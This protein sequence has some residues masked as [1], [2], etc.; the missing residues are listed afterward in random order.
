[1]KIGYARVSTEGQS[2]D[3]QL[4]ALRAEK[5]DRIFREKVSGGS[6]RNRPELAKAIDALGK[7]DVLVVAEWDRA[8]RSLNDGLMLIARVNDRGAR[9]KVLDRPFLDLTSAFGRG[10]MALLSGLAEDERERINRR[11]AEG[12]KAA[13]RRGTRMG[14]P[15]ALN[16]D[17]VRHARELLGQSYSTRAVARILKVSPATISRVRG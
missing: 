6:T 8:T 17:Q 7:G 2:L 13:R 11:A 9:L 12:R 3:R 16:E 4:G 10:V 14:R 5:C 1:M 15:P